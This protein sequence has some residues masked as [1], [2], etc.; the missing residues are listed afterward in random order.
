D[1][2]QQSIAQLV[3]QSLAVGIVEI[4]IHNVLVLLGRI[5]GIFDR[6]VGPEA[7]PLRMLA[8]PRVVRGALDSEIERHLD[9]ERRGGGDETAEIRERAEFRVDGA[10][11]A[12]RGTDRVGAAGIARLR[13]GAVV[14]AFAV[15]PADRMDRDEIDNVETEPRD[16]RKARNAILEAGALAG[17]PPL[18]ARKHFIPRSKARRFA[19]DDDLELVRITHDIAARL[20]TLRQVAQPRRQ[21]QLGPSSSIA[22]IETPQ[23]LPDLRGI[24]GPGLAQCGRH[25]RPA[26]DEFGFDI[27]TRFTFLL[28]FVAPAFE[29]IDPRLDC[30]TPDTELIEAEV[31]DPTIVVE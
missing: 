5:L 29:R 15:D 19:V 12:F 16:L 8:H 9:S 26:F 13:H 28:E 31:A 11:A 6:T 22:A 4:D 20:T 18:T 7:E 1:P 21:H 25:N 24:I 3:P 30:V 27:L 2:E 10:V 23:H 17:H 14:L